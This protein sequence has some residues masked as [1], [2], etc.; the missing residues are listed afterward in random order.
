M[1]PWDLGAALGGYTDH[2]TAMNDPRAGASQGRLA[3]RIAV[4]TGAASGIGLAVARLFAAEGARVA[5]VDRD[6]PAAAD[7]GQSIQ[8]SGGTARVYAGD[9]AE[10]GFAT[11]TVRTITGA[12][13]APGIL[14]TAAGTSVGK[15]VTETSE[16]EWDRVLA[17]NAKG[18]FL[19]ARAVLPGMT[20]AKQG[21][22]VTVGSQ[23]ALAG[24][25]NSASYVAS[26]G[27]VI[28]LTRA[29]AVDHA[30]A[31][32]RAN[33]LLPGAIETAMLQRAFARQSDPQAARSRSA[34]RHAMGRIGTPE[35][36]ARAALFL[37]SDDSSF[38]TGA[39]LPVDGGWLAL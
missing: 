31:G 39:V 20:K 15:T 32:I 28:S 18:T 10:A 30:A 35:E 19:W 7:A 16:E 34:A 25:R 11:E 3:G 13:G 8:R 26:K 4:V 12:W 17:V 23:L 6:A 36:C 5:L 38:T 9:V 21:A 33:V 14:V 29:I 24:G 22:I 27:A 37:A 1:R 2:G